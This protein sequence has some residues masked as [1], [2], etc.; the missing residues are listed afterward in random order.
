MVGLGVLGAGL[1][2]TNESLSLSVVGGI[3][4]AI[5]IAKGLRE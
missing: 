1:W 2:L 3:V 5:G 4:L